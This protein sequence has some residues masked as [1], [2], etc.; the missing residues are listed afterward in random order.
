M[1][2]TRYKLQNFDLWPLSVTL[3][4]DIESWVLYATRLHIIVNISTKYHE[5]T[6]I[7]CEVMAR[8]RY[9]LQNFDL[10][11]LSV[12]LTFDIESWVLYATRLLIMLNISTKL[13]E[14]T[15]M[16]CEVTARTRSDEQ[17]TAVRTD[18]AQTLTTNENCGDYVSLTASGLDKNR[19]YSISPI[20]PQ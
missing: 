6:T 12:T 2:R 3:T 7:T 17:H 15:T 10:W 4:F 18:D 16:T 13:Y 9:K 14:N 20:P 5:D 19:Y 11:P 8:T 1:A